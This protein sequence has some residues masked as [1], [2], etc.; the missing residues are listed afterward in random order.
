MRVG[1]AA[2]FCLA[3][4]WFGTG[5]SIAAAAEEHGLSQ[6]AVEIARPFG[7]PI[8]NSMFVCWMVAAGLV[9]FVQFATRRMKQVPDGA[10]NFLEWLVEGLYG[11]LE[12]IVGPHLAKKTFWFFGSIFIFILAA[13]WFSLIPGVGT[14]GWGHYAGGKFIV[15]EPLLRG[16]NADLNLT[17]A[18]ALSFFVLWLFWS[19][20]EVGV[21]GFL[22]DMFAP[23]VR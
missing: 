5:A 6:G 13:N 4:A 18:M 20:Q 19:I 17:F 22:K 16:A 14:I 23:R 3:A 21:K 2:K 1:V 8:T 15:D 9:M 7:F 10:Q 12:G 11:F